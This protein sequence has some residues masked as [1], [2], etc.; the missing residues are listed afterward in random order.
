MIELRNVNIEFDKKLIEDGTIKIY[1][2]KIT[3]IIGESGSGKTSLLYLL[4]LISSNHRYLYSFDDVTLD[5]S[6]DFEMSRIR[7]QKIGY[8]F[9][10]NNLVEN[11]TIFENIRLSATIAGINITDKEIKS[12]LEFVE[13]GY[14]DSNHYPRKLSGG[15]RQRVAIACALAKQPELILADEPTSALDTVNSEIIMGIFKKIAH[16][17]KKKIVIATHNDRIYNEADVIYEIKNNKIQLVKGES[18]NESSKKEPEDYDNNVK[19]TPRF[20]FDYAIKTSRKGRFAKNLMIVLSAIAIAFS[21]VMYN[22]GD[23]FVKEQEK[24]MDAISDKEI[25]VV[26]MTA[27][28]NTILDIDENLS[29]QDKDAELLR[30]ISYVDT[31]YPYFEF[32]SIGYPLINE[33]EASEGYIVVSKGQKEEKY[34]FA[35]SKDNPYDKYVIIPYYPEQNLERRLKEKLSDESSDKVYISSQLAQLL[36]IENLKE[37]VSLRVLTYVPIAQHETQMTVRPEGIV[38]EID[39]DLSKV[40]ELDL[41]I[42][43]ILDESVRNRY[44]NSGNNAIYVPYHKMQM[45]L[46]QTQNSATIDTNLE[47]IEWR[48]SAF[49]VFAKSYNDVGL[50]IERVSSI[51]PNFRAVSEYQDIESM[52]AIVKNTREIGLVIVIVILIIIF[53]LMSIIHMN[54]ILD[55]KYEISLLK[56]NG[57]TKIELTKL[58]SVESLRHVFLVS[59]ISSVISLVVTKVMNLLF[60]EIA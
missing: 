41:K 46:T 2:G 23:T 8:I 47:Y 34:T 57:L 59:L 11:L 30:N 31:I 25:F 18:S 39:I 49:V 26:N 53:L 5:L 12:Y 48:P 14:I 54:H 43:G 60:E 37:S 9:Q 4:G 33:T 32:R 10:D 45:I 7:K 20:Y 50:V 42:E 15:E 58:V 44:S 13:L 56:A 28:L 29:I 40:V 22:F 35:E 19:L 36:G 38:Y 27:P 17:D 1:D 52:N 3:A 24:L 21:S 55:R 51:N 6:N 16:K